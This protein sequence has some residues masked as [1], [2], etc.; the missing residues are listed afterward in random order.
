MNARYARPARPCRDQR[1][2]RG[3]IGSVR[4]MRLGCWLALWP[5]SR[6]V[7]AIDVPNAGPIPEEPL[8]V[9]NRGAEALTADLTATI[10]CDHAGADAL[11]PDLQAGH[12]LLATLG[13]SIDWPE[14]TV[15]TAP[16]RSVPRIR[17]STYPAS[18]GGSRLL[19]RGMVVTSCPSGQR[20]DRGRR[21][22]RWSAPCDCVIVRPAGRRP[23]R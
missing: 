20:R 3:A 22:G 10:S 6:K 8:S 16:T 7:S 5:P 17:L 23:G 11:V 21:Q 13:S 2:D 19:R 4:G 18:S 9:I 14:A 1:P 15:R 12:Q